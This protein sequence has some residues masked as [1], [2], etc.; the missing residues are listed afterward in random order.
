MPFKMKD[1]S[2]KRRKGDAFGSSDGLISSG[3]GV[4]IDDHAALQTGL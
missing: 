1:E 2:D 4:E 3:T